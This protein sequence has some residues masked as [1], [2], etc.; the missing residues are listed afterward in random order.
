M[1]TLH[2][3]LR[4]TPSSMTEHCGTCAAAATS[5]PGYQE[6]SLS[7]YDRMH[8]EAICVPT[9]NQDQSSLHDRLM[10]TPAMLPSYLS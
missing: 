1:R 4:C 5:N 10:L 6:Q 8:V 3:C 9:E 7:C 2:C